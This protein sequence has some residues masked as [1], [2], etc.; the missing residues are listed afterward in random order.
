VNYCR[1]IAVSHGFN[2]TRGLCA[3]PVA[4]IKGEIRDGIA[5]WWISL[6]VRRCSNDR[7]SAAFL[8]RGE[9][10][11]CTAARAEN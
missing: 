9:P 4:K 8:A 7:C 5:E 3:V 6:F 1:C 10:R 2:R 11:G